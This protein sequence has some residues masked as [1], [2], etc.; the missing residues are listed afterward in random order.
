VPVVRP[1]V[2]GQGQA[3]LV[4]ISSTADASGVAFNGRP[5]PIGGVHFSVATTVSPLTSAKVSAVLRWL[6]AW[7]V[8]NPRKFTEG[9]ERPVVITESD[10]VP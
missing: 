8:A 5:G 2:G 6:D 10:V 3:L 4:E 1:L 7:I 9:V